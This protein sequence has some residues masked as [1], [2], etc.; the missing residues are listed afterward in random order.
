VLPDVLVDCF[1]LSDQSIDGAA[2]VARNISE[3]YH[4]RKIRILPV[5]CGSTRGRRRRSTPDGGWPAPSSTGCRRACRARTW[6]GMGIGRDP[7][8]SYYNY[9][10]TLATFGDEAG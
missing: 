7:Y 10:E 6:S 9:E 4:E 8:R 5:R 1:T 2:S 3:R